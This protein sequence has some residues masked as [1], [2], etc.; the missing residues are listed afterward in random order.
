MKRVVVT[1]VGVV[2]PIG[3]GAQTFWTAI[4]AWTTCMVVTIVISLLTRPRPDEE[5]RG[6]VSGRSQNESSLPQ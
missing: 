2:S 5:L 1:G 4:T 6:L 3:I